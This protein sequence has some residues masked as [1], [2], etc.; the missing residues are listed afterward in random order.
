VISVG[1]LLW[2]GGGKTPVTAAI[3]AHL[4]DRPPGRSGRGLRVAILSRGYGRDAGPDL[5]VR[6]VSTGDGPLLGPWVAGDEPVLLADQLPGVT[7]LV[8]IWSKSLSYWCW[9]ASASIWSKTLCSIAFTPPQACLGHTDIRVVSMGQR[10][11]S[12]IQGGCGGAEISE[13]VAGGM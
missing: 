11:T 13:V 10:N 7:V 6:V 8:A 9:T 12:L 1:N 4:R 3:A 2:G 5:E